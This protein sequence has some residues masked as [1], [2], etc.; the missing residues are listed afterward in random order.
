MEIFYNISGFHHWVL[1]GGGY[2]PHFGVIGPFIG[3]GLIILG[4]LLD[5]DK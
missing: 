3:S 1:F 5:R 2:N 4:I